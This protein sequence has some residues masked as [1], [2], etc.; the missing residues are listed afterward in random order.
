MSLQ[1]TTPNEE[2]EEEEEEDESGL[3]PVSSKFALKVLEQVGAYVMQQGDGDAALQQIQSPENTIQQM[4][5]SSK[6]QTTIDSY[7]MRL[8]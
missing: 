7:F 5:E 2:A 1:Q 4:A 8:N 3:M 6:K